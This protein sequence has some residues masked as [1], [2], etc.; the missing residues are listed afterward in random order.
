MSSDDNDGLN[1]GSGRPRSVTAD[2]DNAMAKLYIHTDGIN[3]SVPWR[4]RDYEEKG[5]LPDEGIASLAEQFDLPLP[6]VEQL[7]ILVGN[8]LDDESLVNFTAVMRDVAIKRANEALEDAARLGKRVE[9]D[10]ARIGD[11]LAPL[12]DAFVSEANQ[13]GVL[14]LA[15]ERAVAARTGATGLYDAIDIVIGRPGSA[16]VMSPT[17][18]R[19]IGDGRRKNVVHSCCYAWHDAGRRVSYTTRPERTADQ[20]GGP[21]IEFIQAVVMMVT[22]PPA[23]LSGETIRKDIERWESEEAAKERYWAPMP[24]RKT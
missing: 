2:R 1:E 3:M 22:D 19:C 13:Q 14:A 17:D 21:L 15:Q 10:L 24:S 9:Q 4:L 11:L 12:S 20:R 23:R 7:S 5:A 8:S 18:K 6:I 16:A